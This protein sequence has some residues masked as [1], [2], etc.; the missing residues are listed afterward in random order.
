MSFGIDQIMQW[1]GQYYWPFVRISSMFLIAP[2][3]SAR[4]IPVN[5]RLYAALAISVAV[6]PS[7]SQ[8]PV[9]DIFTWRG[10]LVT[11]QQ[12]LIGVAIGTVFLIIFQ[13]FVMGGHMVAM[14]MGLAF[15]TMVD[16]N[17]GTQSPVISQF[18][19][20]VATI[21]FVIL[22]GH[23]ILI[24]VIVDSFKTLPLGVNPLSA[25]SFHQIVLF[26]SHIFSGGVAL[27]LPV[28]TTLL[29]I[30]IALGVMTKA[31]PQLN[32]FS[33]GFAITL[34]MGFWLL[35]L[36]LPQILP[37][38]LELFD[39]AVGFQAQLKLAH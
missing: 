24:E 17:T 11:I 7:I 31:A 1:V 13:A 29:F 39:Q 28:I 18:Y 37:D 6:A 15:S 25:E 30:N 38:F 2:L 26:G 4:S 8:L 20:L 34:L 36:S 10:L 16:P 32:I 21:L 5:L 3:F 23:L 19:T 9:I 12:L 33:V 14:G 35:S 27:A 22:D